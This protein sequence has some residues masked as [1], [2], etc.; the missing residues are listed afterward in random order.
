MG[1]HV[2]IFM[3]HRFFSHENQLLHEINTIHHIPSVIIQGRYDVVCPM[4]TV[5]YL[6]Q[7]F[8][9][10]ELNVVPHTGHSAFVAALARELVIAT[11]RFVD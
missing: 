7:A 8:P 2:G 6:K 11:D 5:F 1:Q 3:N 9:E 4:Q 10:A